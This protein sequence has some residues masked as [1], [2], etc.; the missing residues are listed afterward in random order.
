MNLQT[1]IRRNSDGEIRELRND[2]F[3]SEY[4][5]DPE[6]AN[7][8][9][10]DCWRAYHFYQDYIGGTRDSKYDGDVPCGKSK[11]SVK[12]VN[13]DTGEIIKDFDNEPV[14]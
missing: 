13:K 14:G 6:L 7:E 12:H 11:Y 9:G 3:D 10:C 5:F 2:C 4:W 1:F 8:H